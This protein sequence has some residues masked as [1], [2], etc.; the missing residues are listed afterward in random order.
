MSNFLEI[1]TRNA[2]RGF[3]VLPLR[4]KEAFLKRWPDLATTD[5]RQIREWAAKFPHHNCGVA[6]GS[7]VIILDSDR[8]SRLRELCGE[9]WAEWF[10]TYSVSSGRPDR[11]HFY[12]LSTPEVLEFGNRKHEEPGIKGNIFE[13]KGKGAQATAE[14]SVHPDTGETYYI[15][16]D[17]PLIPFPLELLALLREM[18]QES[19]PTGKREWNLP[20][21]D[22]EGRDDF[23]IQQAGRLRN[24]G[25]SEDIIRAHLGEINADPE[26]MADPKSEADLDRIARSA[27][28]YDVP[29]PETKLVLGSSQPKAVTDWREYYHTVTDHDNVGPPSF[30][31]DG[32][33]PEQAI[34]GIGAF[35]GQKKTLAALNIVLS[36][37]SGEPLFG[38]YKVTRKPSRVLYLGPENGL[39]SFSDRVNRIG[40]REYLCQTF[41]YST[42]SIQETRPL[43]ALMP[44]EIEDA[45]IVIDT[46]IRFTDG[47]E[48]DAAMM[49]EFA[50]HAFSLIRNKAACVI[51]L[52][53][54]PKSMTK[55]NELTLENSFRGTGELSAFLS[56]ALAMRTQD[57]NNE[58]ESASLLRFVKQR[59]FEPKPSSFEVKTNRET[60]RMAFV[61]GSA[62]AVVT[63]GNTANKDGKDDT[64]A[65]LMKANP[66]LSNVKMAKFLTDAGIKRSKEWVRLKRGELGIGGLTVKVGSTL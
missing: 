66:H 59:D 14:G 60:C 1:A 46:A 4:G 51:M 53:H 64:A 33:L 8:V 41:F 39:I 30:L 35:V 56:V 22:G 11:A 13:V 5:E 50:N 40:L 61:D 21:H 15:T 62:G 9:C 36:L 52:H 24:A 47:S 48:N 2:R 65:V 29:A 7:D 16:Q 44:E 31:I 34:M 63:L 42:M 18:W 43:A 45:A 19:N 26:I 6:G 20:V 12:F 27:A 25:A 49:K 38:K 32:F 28:R 58:Y 23:L 54:S 57:M 17:L 37:C 3:R 55:A 10:H